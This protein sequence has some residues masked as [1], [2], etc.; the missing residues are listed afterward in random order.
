MLESEIELLTDKYSEERGKPP[1]LST[2]TWLSQDLNG[3]ENQIQKKGEEFKFSVE[4]LN[5]CWIT[6]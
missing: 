6:T 1:L 5:H 4:T 3:S 2:A